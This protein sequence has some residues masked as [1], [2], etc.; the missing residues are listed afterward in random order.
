MNDNKH[1]K[2]TVMIMNIEHELNSLFGT[3]YYSN[4]YTDKENEILYKYR[5]YAIYGWTRFSVL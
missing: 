5:V 1:K 3:Y 4:K 2:N